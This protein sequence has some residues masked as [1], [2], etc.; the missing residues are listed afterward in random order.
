[1]TYRLKQ[2]YP[3]VFCIFCRPLSGARCPA[4]RAGQRAPDSGRQ[5]M[6][7]GVQCRVLAGQSSLRRG[8]P[9]GGVYSSC[10]N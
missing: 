3:R 4:R 2:A 7:G 10:Y 1:M 5:K 8:E 9:G 6:Q